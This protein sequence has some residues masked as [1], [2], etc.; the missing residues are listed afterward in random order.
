MAGS[1][2]S[3]RWLSTDQTANDSRRRSCR[4]ISVHQNRPSTGSTP[5]SRSPISA[6]PCAR[7]RSEPATSAD[8]RPVFAITTSTGRSMRRA[9]PID[10]VGGGEAGHAPPLGEQVR[11]END[12]PAHLRE[13]LAHAAHQQRRHQ[14]GEE[15]AR[16]DDDGV[17]A[18]DRLATAGWID[19][20][21]ARARAGGP[22]PPLCRRPPP[23]R[24][25]WPSRRRTRRRA[26]PARR[27]PA[28]HGPGTR[29]AAQAVHGA[30]K[31]PL[32][33]SI[34]DSSR[35]PPV[36]PASRVMML[37]HRQPRQQHAARLALVARE[38]ERALQH[39]ARRQHAQLVAQLSG[40]AAAVEHRDDGVHLEPGIRLE[41][42]QQARKPGAAAD[43]ADVQLAQLHRPIL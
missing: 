29:A 24:R 4:A 20:G 37:E 3:R 2:R 23:P 21:R 28:R 38:R 8:G 6:A 26:T 16:P 43:A 18:A 32:Y 12:R 30:R 40:A 13:R 22:A 34:I 9:R 25:A 14:A 1:A 39:V 27:S 42:A 15:A 35:L 19:T 7:R 36:W 17:E 41:P 10:R 5:G 31:S 33:C 11:D